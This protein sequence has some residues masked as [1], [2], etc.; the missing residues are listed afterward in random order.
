MNNDKELKVWQKPVDL[1]V[2]IYQVTKDFLKEEQY[3]LTS[4]VRRSVVS[5]PS[6]IAEGFGRN[7][8]N[9]FKNF[10]GISNGSTCELNTQLII[11]QRINFIELKVLESIQQ[12]IAE[13]QK[14]TW[15]LQKSLV[16]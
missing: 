11:A 1:A 12:E 13:I 7:S 4:Q 6:N 16:G 15:S 3:G 8:K 10:L 2:K 5:I 14:M 9:D